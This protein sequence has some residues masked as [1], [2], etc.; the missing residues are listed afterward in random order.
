MNKINK[1]FSKELN[2]W[3][4][5]QILL[6]L[7]IEKK[8]KNKIHVKNTSGFLKKLYLSSVILFLFNE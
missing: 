8:K 5:S 2:Y 7:V 3:R 1:E 6:E 4:S